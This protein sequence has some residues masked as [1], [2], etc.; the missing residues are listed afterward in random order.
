MR[1]S[2]CGGLPS[3]S[4]QTNSRPARTSV[5]QE[6][7]RASFG[8]RLAYG[9]SLQR[10][11]ITSYNVCYTKLLRWVRPYQ[12]H[13]KNLQLIGLNDPEKRWVLKNPSHLIALEAVFATYPDALVI[14]CHRLV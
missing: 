4:C 1:T 7:V 12:R 6:R 14:Q 9:T 8:V 11:R 3:W 5:C 10:P 2:G 13:R